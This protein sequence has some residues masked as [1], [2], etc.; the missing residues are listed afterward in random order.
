MFTKVEAPN[1]LEHIYSRIR[2]INVEGCFDGSW[3]VLEFG[4]DLPEGTKRYS[5]VNLARTLGHKIRIREL[6]NGFLIRKV[7]TDAEA[8]DDG[9]SSTISQ[10]AEQCV[11]AD[12][13]SGA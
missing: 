1:V 9:G 4:R 8:S 2:G 11:S 13:E 12:S 5:V 10:D 6:T 3:W 7:H